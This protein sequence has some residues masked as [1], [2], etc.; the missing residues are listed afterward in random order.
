MSNL[1]N[2]AATIASIIA[3][4]I[5]A[6]VYRNQALQDKRFESVEKRLESVE[7][8]QRRNANHKVDCQRDFVSAEQWVR[9]EAYTRQKL[10]AIAEAVSGLTGS[11]KIVEQMPQICGQIARE[12]VKEFKR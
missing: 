5:S 7:I 8:E 11:L 4:V 3:A 9:S 1:V 2:I 10:D 6:L 12:I